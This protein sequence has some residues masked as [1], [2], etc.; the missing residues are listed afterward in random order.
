MTVSFRCSG[1]GIAPGIKPGIGDPL[2][3][4]TVDSLNTVPG[5]P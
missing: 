2:K 3:E 1:K 4:V 5:I